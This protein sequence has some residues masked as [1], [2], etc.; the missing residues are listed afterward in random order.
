MSPHVKK[1]ITLADGK[2]IRIRQATP[3]EQES[4]ETRSLRH[5]AKVAG[6]T[7]VA[8]A[9]SKGLPITIGRAGKLIQVYPD[10]REVVL[11]ELRKP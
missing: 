9:F 11:G 2:V 7:A 1:E 5:A 8:K 10:G 3:A 6:E 4:A